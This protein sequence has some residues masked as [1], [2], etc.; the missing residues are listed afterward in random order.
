MLSTPFFAGKTLA[1][2]FPDGNAKNDLRDQTHCE[3]VN[4]LFQ[5]HKRSQLF[6]CAYSETFSV[7]VRVYN[8][9]IF[10]STA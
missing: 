5:F 2:R 10:A 8:R 3:F 9:A 1:F 7:A 4:R 6:I